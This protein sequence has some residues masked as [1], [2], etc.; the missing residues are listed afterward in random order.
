MDTSFYKTY[1]KI[2]KEHWLMKVRRGIIQ[3][4]LSKYIQKKPK[5]VKL[6]DFGCGSGLFVD[7]LGKDGF[8]AYGLDNSEEAIKFGQSKGI[9]NIGVIGSQKISFPDNT[10]D[11]VLSLDVLEHLENESWALREIE[12]VL[13]SGGIAII[14]VPAYHF[15]WGVQDDVSHHFRRYTKG[16]L[17]R[18]I[19]KSTSLEIIRSSYY[20]TFL[21][22]P[23]AAV[24]LLSRLF[25]WKG[26]ESDYDLNSPFLNKILFFIFNTE[27][28]L[29]KKIN[30]PF[31][32][33][34]LAV[35]K[36]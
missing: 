23:I 1:F 33:S 35:L 12:R 10:F 22:P 7:E 2:E 15:L 11:A 29:L 4:N 8:D 14:T 5:D 13:K 24:R 34:I 31:G 20:N 19:K 18:E 3:D 26:R 27:R 32:V 28:K 21:F 25:K 9:K 36:K 16:W 17:L 30:Y 6:L